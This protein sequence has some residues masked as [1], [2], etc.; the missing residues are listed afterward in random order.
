MTVRTAIKPLTL[1]AAA[2]LLAIVLTGCGSSPPAERPAVQ[3]PVQRSVITAPQTR[4]IKPGMSRQRFVKKYGP[5]AAP[6]GPAAGGMRCG[7]YNLPD[8][9]PADVQWLVCFKRDKLTLFR[10][11]I[12]ATGTG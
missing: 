6:F 5:P 8:R 11:D 7:S 2:V 12:H 3:A 4:Q 9:D 1:T 10:T